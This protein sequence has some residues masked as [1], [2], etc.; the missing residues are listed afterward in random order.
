MWTVSAIQMHPKGLIVCDEDATL[1]LHV[2]VSISIY[3]LA[4]IITNYH[5]DCKILQ[6]YRTC[7]SFIN[8]VRKFIST[9]WCQAIKE[10]IVRCKQSSHNT[11]GIIFFSI[12]MGMGNCDFINEKNSF[13]FF[14]PF[15]SLK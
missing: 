14:F 1:E 5:I 10:C 9:R 11:D 13:F 15:F 3:G 12:I 2:K 6:I 8:W 4:L 7:S